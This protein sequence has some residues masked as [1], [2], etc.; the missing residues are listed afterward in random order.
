VAEKSL[1]VGAQLNGAGGATAHAVPVLSPDTQQYAV[2]LCGYLTE[3]LTLIPD[4]TWRE[5]TE[6]V[7]C[8]Q[9]TED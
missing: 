3:H 4:M 9:C 5:V 6:D 7:R 2:A 8:P 1:L